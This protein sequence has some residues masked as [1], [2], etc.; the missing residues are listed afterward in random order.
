MSYL[1]FVRHGQSQ[2]NADGM[3]ADAHSPLTKQGIAQARKTAD[4]IRDLG[5]RTV[6]C[7]P[8]L[9]AQQTAEIIAGEI[10][11]ELDHVKV[12]DALRERGLGE[13]E[14]KPKIYE[15][16]WYYLSNDAAGIEKTEALYD[17]MLNCLESIKKI[18]NGQ[19]ILVVGHSISGFYFLQ[20][21]SQKTSL[22]SFDSPQQLNNADFVKVELGA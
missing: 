4:G 12:L 11:V 16:L 1:I 21:A 14:G 15:S 6:V 7:S 18:A 20:L 8:F 3:I 22:E 5:I 17:R 19:P 13:L 10:G 9:R 2:A